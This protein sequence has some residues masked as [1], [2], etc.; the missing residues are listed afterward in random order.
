[1]KSSALYVFTSSDK[2]QLDQIVPL[3]HKADV[4]GADVVSAETLTHISIVLL[5]VPV[6]YL[7]YR[8]LIPRLSSSAKKLATVM[9]VGQALVIVLSLISPQ[10]SATDYRFW[11]LDYE[12]NLPTSLAVAQLALV[13]AV[14]L[15]TACLG[16]WR[17][18]GRRLILAAIGLFFLFLAQEEF[19]SLRPQVLGPNWEL[20]YAA[21]GVAVAVVIVVLAAK[22]PR[23][24]RIWQFCLLA[25]LAMGAIGALVIEQFRFPEICGPLG[26]MPEANRCQLYNV[27]ESLE[28]LGVWLALVAVLGM[29]SEV[30]PAP[31]LRVRFFLYL[32]PVSVFVLL[33]LDSR[34]VQDELAGVKGN[35]IDRLSALPS[36]FEYQFLFQRI[37]VKYETDVELRAYR[38]DHGDRSLDL[39][40]FASVAS[41]HDY[42]GLGYSLHLVDQVS[43]ES[44]VGSDAAASRLHGYRLG[45]A[46]RYIYRQRI[47]VEI[48]SQTPANR[49]LWIVLTVWREDEA[50]FA[51]QKIT[52]SDQQL[53]SDT[54]VILGELVIPAES[55]AS[56]PAA[57]ALLD[58]AITLGLVDLP[59]RAR[60]GETLAVSFDWRAEKEV[61][62]DYV[63]FLHFGN[64]ENGVEWVYD[65]EPLGARLPTR[66]WYSGVADSE[67]WEIPLPAVLAPGRYHVFTRL[68]RASDRERL[69]A[70]D[71]EGT[72]FPDAR[73]PLGSIIIA[74]A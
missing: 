52:S 54:Q 8:R 55:Q 1:M 57:L 38:L 53:L 69:R 58:G 65:Q 48:P 71:V 56:A 44:A 2:L 21:L 50:G 9:L 51:R 24:A 15:F 25:G 13:G 63:Q 4:S 66:L 26:F 47:V 49:A 19:L 5:Y 31:R 74:R 12:R 33:V 64:E 28:F 42:S 40:F 3:R 41:W 32:L 34:F 61:A 59:K 23:R 72:P 6:C 39:Q 45:G 70:S 18:A 37:S 60:S 10:I 36:R 35:F 14:A 30:A 62:E 22:S 16:H 67:T 27:E 20:Y 17:S 68:Y 7:V 29:F 73:V 11:D 43:G 46:P